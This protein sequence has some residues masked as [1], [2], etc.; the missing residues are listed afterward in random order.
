MLSLQT[1]V[2]FIWD[3][4]QGPRLCIGWAGD[5][6]LYVALLEDPQIKSTLQNVEQMKACIK[7]GYPFVYLGVALIRKAH[8]LFI[9]YPLAHIDTHSHQVVQ[10]RFHLH[11]YLRFGFTVLTS[12]QEAAKDG[13]MVMPQK[14]DQAR[15]YLVIF[16]GDGKGKVC[17]SGMCV[18]Q[19]CAIH[20]DDVFVWCLGKGR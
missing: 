4:S 16:W 14:N 20:F 13:K 15:H 9:A 6:S 8:H 5:R 17:I 3:L 12:F 18:L 10:W 19:F 2:V 1:L 11:N 7:H